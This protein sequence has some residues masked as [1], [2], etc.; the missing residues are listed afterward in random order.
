M[1][2][3][4]DHTGRRVTAARLKHGRSGSSAAARLSV[5]LRVRPQQ[6]RSEHR[7]ASYPSAL[8]LAEEGSI[9]KLVKN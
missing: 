5:P 8:S 3:L 2:P 4:T 6:S 7:P 1:S 9:M